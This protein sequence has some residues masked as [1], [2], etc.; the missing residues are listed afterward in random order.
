MQKKTDLTYICTQLCNLS[1]APVRLFDGEKEVY[2][3]SFVSLPKDPMDGFRKE[4]FALN[5]SVGYFSTPYDYYFGV[6]RFSDKR[7]VLGPIPQGKLSEQAIK[8]TAFLCGVK[9]EEREAFVS[10]MKNIPPRPLMTTAQTLCLL[11]HALTGEKLSLVDVS[12]AEHEQENWKKALQREEAKRAI[13]YVEKDTIQPHNTM[14]V[15]KYML[16]LVAKGDVEGLKLFFSNVPSIQGGAIAQDGL[17]QHK[18]LL[19]VTATLVSRA[20]IR[21]GMDVESALSLSDSYIQKSELAQTFDGVTNLHYRLVMDYAERVKAARIGGAGRLVGEVNAYLQKHLSEPVTVEKIAKEIGRGRSRLSTDFKKETG[22]N[23][24]EY[25]LKKKIEEGKI[26]LLYTD[27]PA[28]DIALYLGFSSQSHF[29]RT[30]KKY[31]DTTP[32]EYRKREN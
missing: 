2:Y 26:L 11:Y 29:S 7:I 25:V 18:N 8:E 22:E 28:V 30:F 31:V 20:A 5:T 15:E 23:L 17:R 6:M 13:E 9:K 3:Y 16:E 32:I 27:K 1:G 4:V 12:I 10:A 19:I 21:G 24:A 14:D